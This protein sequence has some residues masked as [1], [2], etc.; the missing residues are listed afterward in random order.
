MRLRN[1]M[2]HRC[3]D[4][5]LKVG[6]LGVSRG[7]LESRRKSSAG[8]RFNCTGIPMHSVI[9]SPQQMT[10]KKTNSVRNHCKD[11]VAKSTNVR[12]SQQSAVHS[13]VRHAV[14]CAASGPRPWTSTGHW[15]STARNITYP[16]VG[17]LLYVVFSSFFYMGRWVHG[18]GVGLD[19]IAFR[20][21]SRD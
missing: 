12:P 13:A 21:C 2:T 6:R 1:A 14:S 10:T 3:W 18:S 11:Q 4:V 8:C 17:C 20:Y 9:T 15:D 16:C 5:K 7:C 19:P